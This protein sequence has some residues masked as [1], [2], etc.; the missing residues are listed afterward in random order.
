MGKDLVPDMS[1]FYEQHKSV[2]P[3][4]ITEPDMDM[5]VENYQSKEDRAKLDG[6]LRVRAVRVLYHL[7]PLVLVERRQ[8]PGAGRAAAVVSLA[9]RQ[10]GRQEG[11]APQV[12]RR[13]LQGLPLS[14]DH[15]L[16]QNLPEAPEPGQGHRGDQ[17]RPVRAALGAALAFGC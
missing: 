14:H 7:V 9:G 5:T 13:R 2:M 17:A 10:P 12:P 11:G 15:E 1:N 3:F 6:L 16:Q 8:V 4:L